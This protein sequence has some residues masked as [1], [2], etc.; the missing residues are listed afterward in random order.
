[1]KLQMEK[2]SELYEKNAQTDI[3]KEIFGQLANGN[4]VFENM[5]SGFEQM[6]RFQ[7]DLDKLQRKMN[8]RTRSSH[9]AT[10]SK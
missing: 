2:Q 7:Q 1:M 9:P 3:T 6:D 8:T 4:S 5:A 10:R